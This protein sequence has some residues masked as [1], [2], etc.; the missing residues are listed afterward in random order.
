VLIRNAEIDFAMRADVRIADGVIA[1]IGRLDA[2]RDD[3]A[4]DARGAALLPGLH[5]HHIHFLAYAASRESVPC[6]PPTVTNA[7]DLARQLTD[8]AAAKPGAWIRGI[9]YHRSVAGDIDR[10]WLDRILP[11]T[12]ARIQERSGR[13]WILNSA[14]LDLVT[15]GQAETPLETVDGR[16]TGRLYDADAWLRERIGHVPLPIAPASRFLASRGVTGLTD[17]TPGNGP[18]EFALLREAQRSGDLVQNVLMMGGAGLDGMDGCAG[19][20]IG[21]RKIHLHETDLPDLADL[22]AIISHSHAAGRPVAVHCV[23][24]AELVFTLGAFD[25]A[26]AAPGD[27]IEHAAVAPPDL[28]ERIAGLGLTVVTQPNFIAERG[29]AYLRD[30]DRAE[31]P[32]LYRLRGFAEAGIALAAGTDAPFGDA[33]PW[34]AMQAAVTRRTGS[35]A[36]IGPGEALTPEQ[37]L[38]LFTGAPADPG[39]PSRRIAVGAKADLCLLD[40]PWREARRDLSQVAVAATVRSGRLVFQA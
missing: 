19:L 23:T 34:K 40:R 18:E 37:A 11:T 28:L 32:W 24:L 3:I 31:Q 30:V 22:S 9:G 1:E 6:G 39:G 7:H 15:A 8:R 2:V 27:R 36:S 26:G 14:A 21:A 20:R 12:P 13:L 5:D 10:D 35:G 33:D 25:E 17:T 29:D 4:I 38:A 16:P